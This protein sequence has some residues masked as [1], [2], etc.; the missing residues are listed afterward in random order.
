MEIK[1]PLEQN[2]RAGSRLPTVLFE[3][4]EPLAATETADEEDFVN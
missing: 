3:Q 4:E 2:N 1:L